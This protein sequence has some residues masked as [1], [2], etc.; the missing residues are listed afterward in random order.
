[1]KLPSPQ[2]LTT[3]YFSSLTFWDGPHS[4]ECFSLNISTSHLSLH[5]QI[6]WRWSK[7]LRFTS[8]N[9][10]CAYF[11]RCL[12][13]PDTPGCC[14][15]S[16]PDLLHDL[17]MVLHFLLY[18]LSNLFSTLQ[19]SPS[20][21]KVNLIVISCNNFL[22]SQVKD[23]TLPWPA[24]FSRT[25]PP[26]AA[27][28]P[29]TVCSSSLLGFQPHWPFSEPWTHHA[30]SSHRAFAQAA[31]GRL[32]SSS[33][34]LVTTTQSYT[35]TSRINSFISFLKQLLYRDFIQIPYN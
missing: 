29:L 24:N 5:P 27:H 17:P 3:L 22:C 20:Y 21:H 11:S 10:W 15:P 1:M 9:C 7:N 31:A 32:C 4:V 13:W 34:T 16:M 19:F 35:T 14:L 26:T 28:P 8:N 23:K 12:W 30:L 18:L 25:L 6:L 33:F 2:K